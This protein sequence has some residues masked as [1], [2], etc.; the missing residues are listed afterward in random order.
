VEHDTPTGRRDDD[1]G[2]WRRPAGTAAVEAS[3]L[4]GCLYAHARAVLKRGGWV[5]LGIYCQ[6]YYA[7]EDNLAALDLYHALLDDYYR[8]A[9]EVPVDHGEERVCRLQG[10]VLADYADEERGTRVWCLNGRRH[11]QDLAVMK[12]V[13]RF[14]GMTYTSQIHHRHHHQHLPLPNPHAS[15]RR[16][17]A[18]CERARVSVHAPAVRTR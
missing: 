14:R 2:A 17:G 10:L 7:N 15:E 6:P 4:M 12:E 16:S 13:A 11:D 3:S 1:D 18:E 9:K 5:Y 8:S